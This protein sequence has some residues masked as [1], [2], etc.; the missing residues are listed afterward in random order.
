[1]DLNAL[2]CDH[3]GSEEVYRGLHRRRR[4]I[5]WYLLMMPVMAVFLPLAFARP[6]EM[7]GAGAGAL[8]VVFMIQ[9]VLIP[10]RERWECRDCG[11]TWRHA[12]PPHGEPAVPA[13]F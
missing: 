6:N 10:L 8:L 5:L 4:M 1:M 12:E 11:A 3:C 13:A 2:R 7:L 9:P